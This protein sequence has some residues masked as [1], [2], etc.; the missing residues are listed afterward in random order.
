METITETRQR[1]ED[2]NNKEWQE[3]WDGLIG[4]AWERGWQNDRDLAYHLKYQEMSF[5]DDEVRDKVVA[6]VMTPEFAKAVFGEPWEECQHIL[7]TS[8]QSSGTLDMKVMRDLCSLF[9]GDE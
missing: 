3:I 6:T 1:L 2:S 8:I 5:L 4:V 7:L 9:G